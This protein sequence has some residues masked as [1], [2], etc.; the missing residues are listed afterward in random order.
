MRQRNVF[1]LLVILTICTCF[2]S[3]TRLVSLADESPAETAEVIFQSGRKN[4]YKQDW[5]KAVVEFRKIVEEFPGSKHIE[6]SLYW[7][8]YG[9]NK[10]GKSSANFEKRLALQQEAVAELETLR[11]RYP[12]SKWADDAEIL[13]IEI[14][15]DLAAQG[16][17]KYK[18]Y[19]GQRAQEEQDREIKM[20]AI[21]S[22]MR[23]DRDKAFTLLQNI[24][25]AGEDEK[26]MGQAIFLLGQSRDE[27][28]IPIYVDIALKG[29]KREL[30]EQAIFW[31]GQFGTPRS[32][33]ELIRLYE[34]IADIKLKERLLFSISQS[35]GNEAV[36]QM[37]RIYK[38]EKSLHLKKQIIFWL[39]Q[40]RDK[41]AETFIKEIL[42]NKPLP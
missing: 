23:T 1:S 24:L 39:G 36:K 28:V 4:I 13:V 3:F 35:G 27:R 6:D 29:E 16:L 17:S 42:N 21:S 8:G 7:L 5:Q 14:A 25:R 38:K 41:D 26:L 37:I 31:L 32:F 10:L 19:I 20:A 22:L 18:T 34:T 12:E 15:D 33:E 30:R 2:L 9:L 11:E 40:S